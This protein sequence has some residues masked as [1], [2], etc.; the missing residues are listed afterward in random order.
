MTGWRLYWDLRRRGVA[1]RARDGRIQ[2]QG[3]ITPEER[4]AAQVHRAGLLDV[5]ATVDLADRFIDA[6]RAGADLPPLAS[7]T[8]EECARRLAAWDAAS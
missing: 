8:R 1:L 4:A 3:A 2:A 7:L 5:L 6:I